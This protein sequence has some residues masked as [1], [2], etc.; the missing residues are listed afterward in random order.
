[1]T[2]FRDIPLLSGWLCC[3]SGTW[4][5]LCLGFGLS[6][7]K[8]QT[9]PAAFTRTISTTTQSATVQF[10]LHPIRSSN[11][12]VHVQQA[13]GSF[14]TQAADVPRT[15]LGT[16]NGFPGAIAIGLLRADNTLLARLSFE[17]GSTWTTTGGTATASSSP[18]VPE[19][20]TTVVGTGGAGSAVQAAEVGLDSTFNHFTA[21][22]STAAGVL[23]QCEF[24]VM[25]C[26]MVYL[27]DSAI[28]HRIGRVVIRADSAQDPYL[29]DGGDT[30]LLLTRVRTLWN[31]GIPMGTAHDLAAVLHS[32]ANGGL[33]YVGTV[34]TSSRYSSNDSESNGDFSVV[35]RHEAGHNWSSNHYEGGGNPEGN[36]IMSNNALSRFSS[37]E[38][39]KIINHRTGRTVLDNLGSYPF[40]LPPRANQD[41]TSFLR[42]RPVRVDVMA[43]DSDSNG[44]AL[45]LH[46][47]DAASASGAVLT[48]S[49]G[50]GP[51]GRDEVLYT[52]PATL[53]KGTDWFRYR[54][55]D[56][57]G[58]QAIGY[59]M[60]RPRSEILAATDHWRLDGTSGTSALNRVRPS[61]N[62]TLENGTLVNQPGANPV[63]RRGVAFDGV[64][65]RISIPAPNYN[66]AT[67]TFTTWVRRSGS[68]N[69]F[70]GLI[71]TRAGS[72]M[73]GLHFGT[74]N[75]LRYTWNDA[76]FNWLPS[77]ALTVPDNE[78]C[79]AAMGVSPTGTT[80]HLRTAAG[81]RSAS[82]T[83]PITSE[84]FNGLLYLGQDTTSSARC[85]RGSL[86]DV[87]V[88]AAA[89]TPDDIE[90]LYQQAASP[91]SLTLTA[92]AA[93][94]S[95]PP[96]NVGFAATLNSQ[97]WL[98]DRMDFVEA[99]TSAANALLFPWRATA[100][101]LAPGVR[102]FTARAS[103]GDWQYT[104]DSAPVTFTAQPAPLP[105]VNVQ[106]SLSASKRGPVP[107]SFTIT[108][109]HGIG[110]FT[111]PFSIGGTAVAGPDY[112]ALASSS[113]VFPEGS[114]S[115]TVTINPV[116]APPDGLSKTVILTLGSGSTWT[117]G[118]ASATLT[119]DDHITSIAAGLWND[120]TTWNSGA[121][122]PVTGTQ[123]TGT[124]YA[125]GAHVVTSN[126]A[127]SNSQA[128]VAGSLRIRNGG[129]LDL[130]R[131][132]DGTNNN[133][134]YNLPATT[135]ESG[136]TLGFR[137]SNGS[138]THTVAAAISISGNA[139]FQISGGGYENIGN[140]TGVLSGSGQINVVSATNAGG[141]TGFLRRISVNSANNP[142]TGN[143]TVS[144]VDSGDD[145][146]AIRAGAAR[147]L[148][149]GTVT[150]GTRSQLINDAANG[151]N[152]LAGVNLN[153]TDSFL[154]LN[155]PWGNPAASLALTGGNPTV[156]LGNAA[157]VIGTLT[158]TAGRIQGTGS[159]SG[160]TVN[161][162]APAWFAG[163]LGP[164]LS[165]TKSGA[166]FLGLTGSLSPALRLSITQGTLS[167]GNP[168]AT[169]ASLNLSG[170]SLAMDLPPPGLPPLTVSGNMIRTAGNLLVTLPDPAPAPGTEYLLITYQGNLSGQPP[171][172]F[173]PAATA[174]VDYG[175][176]TNSRI[177]VRFPTAYELWAQSQGLSGAA[178]TP[179]A[180][181]DG[182]GL[183]N[184]H[185]RAFGFTPTDAD[186]CLKMDLTRTP[187][188]IIRLVIN[189]VIPT[190]TFTLHWSTDLSPP[191]ANSQ[192]IPI[193][194]PA[195]DYQLTPPAAGSRTFYRLTY[196]SG[197]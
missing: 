14:L 72:S 25:S 66:T 36:T 77:P 145:F 189:K 146:G 56:A 109:S 39:L 53:S 138:S 171:V 101:S 124:G 144:H 23:E 194:A 143:W 117:L 182:D 170:G 196:S 161:Q 187:G 60:L 73:A 83:T 92:P 157:S 164:N 55:Q 186:S 17:D 19:W 137:A 90:S 79:L 1:M 43:N 69:S 91:P 168:P 70:A 180:D 162:A 4:V 193:S 173:S 160:L 58:F 108:R 116:A 24:S 33:A 71:F 11:F 125:I 113:L 29:T 195:T 98:V 34:G 75:E 13:D 155:Q 37:S 20:P 82:H 67:L 9:P 38:N 119:I 184:E 2:R 122:A 95:L 49:A 134:S 148:G 130:A 151:L 131:L 64:N 103:F 22:G 18:F 111:V 86:D 47:F 80:L 84:A 26:N 181:P 48:R 126:N 133:V 3:R 128:L 78:W 185:E 190:G 27:R 191:W 54:I 59:A 31:A 105:V 152:S 127:A 89:L 123:N 135:I 10:A 104:V 110:S 179:G 50:T 150:V 120:A 88:Y 163:T 40:P 165:F 176:G 102:T 115:Q 51:G 114:L 97:S 192:A 149:T 87:R 62:G 28:L 100:V 158:G 6:A 16:V 197:P 174:V 153:G 112:T 5:A 136:G 132:H 74:A 81:L 166:E 172:V 63:T 183:V 46:S 52:P 7:A 45:T 68:Q 154:M 8:A 35:W 142:F 121:A 167:L 32:G 188:G 118:T 76:G 175:T 96:L 94:A 42:N 177:L 140:L 15:Y 44:Q 139:T 21:C 41:A 107:G 169:V 159:A 85:F 141:G 57:A 30:G 93:S 147:A 99:E 129:T 178:A 65:D 106:A 12:Q 61:H 156:Q